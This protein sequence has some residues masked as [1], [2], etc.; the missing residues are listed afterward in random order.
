MIGK[1]VAACIREDQMV[2]QG[3]TEQV[4]TLPESVGEHAIL[5]AGCH[6]ARGVIVGT[7]DVKSR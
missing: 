2:E 7:C 1:A 3:D 4:C 6:I 5:K